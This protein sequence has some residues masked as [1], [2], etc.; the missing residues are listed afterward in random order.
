MVNSLTGSK[1]ESTSA[2]GTTPDPLS[3]GADDND[4]IVV[5]ALRSG[6][7]YVYGDNHSVLALKSQ[8][9]IGIN[10][11]NATISNNA[12]DSRFVSWQGQGRWLQQ[13]VPGT[14]PIGQGRVQFADRSL[15]SLEQLAIY[16][17]HVGKVLFQDILYPLPS[18]L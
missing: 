11:L 13:L 8:V 15:V 1:L 2:L 17:S 4:R 14:D 3:R 10:A 12:P 18:T 7:E 9:N 5:S 6:Q 16:I